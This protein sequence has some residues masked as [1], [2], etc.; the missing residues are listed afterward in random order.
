MR[1]IQTDTRLGDVAVV[2]YV[3]VV[4]PSDE[5]L[6]ANLAKTETR[7]FE[8]LRA[9]PDRVRSVTF[10]YR[11]LFARFGA[12][13]PL[14]RQIETALRDGLKAKNPLVRTLV[15]TE[16]ET[17][18]LMGIQDDETIVGDLRFAPANEGDSFAG[19]RSVVVCRL[20]EPVLRDEEGIIASLIQGPD[21]RTAIT[22]HTRRLALLAFAPPEFAETAGNALNTLSDLLVMGSH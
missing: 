20:G 9:D 18:I 5:Q 10:R 6:R 1:Q 8:G 2:R 12:T 15:L 4:A 3:S 14:E 11:D 7:V 19:M 16:V 22:P 21:A 17:G 13:N